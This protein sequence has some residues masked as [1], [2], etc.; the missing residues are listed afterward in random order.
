[1]NPQD[2]SNKSL[3]EF[4]VIMSAAFIVIFWLLLPWLFER[5]RPIWPAYIAG[6]L[7]LQALIYP[8]S[9]IPVRHLWMR[10]GGV[11]GWINTRII[12]AIVFFLLLTPIGCLQR[13]RKKLNYQTGYAPDSDTYKIPRKQTLSGNDLEN[14]F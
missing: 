8:P 4:A 14:P 6:V 7:I 11:L 5:A 1:M 13:Q 10:L 2:N 9:L 12:L 3:R